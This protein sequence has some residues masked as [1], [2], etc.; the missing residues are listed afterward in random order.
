MSARRPGAWKKDAGD[1]VFLTPFMIFF[2]VFTVIPLVFGLAMGFFRWELVSPLPPEFVGL[3]NFRELWRDRYF[4]AALRATL[5]FTVMIVPASLVISL[6]MAAGLAGLTRRASFYRALIYLPTMLNVAVV[7]IL[8]RWFYAGDFGL[9]NR[10]L[11]HFGLPGLGWLSQTNLA[12]PSVVLMTLWWG[13]GGPTI[14]FLAGIQGIPTTYYEAAVLDGAGAWGRFRHVTL[15]LLRPVLTFVTV[16]SV[17]GSFQVFGQ[18]YILTP[19]GGPE[20]STLT[21]V[22]YIYQTS[23]ENYRLGYG[24]A[25]CGFLLLVIMAVTLAQ[26][27][28]IN[29][30]GPDT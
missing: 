6:A 20:L 7:G 2:L 9:F 19:T 11:A 8:W 16:M 28:L 29:R 26:L 14:I 25:M 27:K 22:Q 18:T 3:D 12:M 10:V 1:Y 17:I 13:V 23:F 21:L 4:L 24:A 30:G 5:M 15:P